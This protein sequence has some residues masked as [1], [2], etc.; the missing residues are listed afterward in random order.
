MIFHNNVSFLYVR[1]ISD[2][3]Q[4]LKQ[5]L[6]LYHLHSGTKE[7]LHAT[8]S[9]RSSFKIWVLGRIIH[10]RVYNLIYLDCMKNS[11]SETHVLFDFAQ[12]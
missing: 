4:Q 6:I 9:M 8:S 1:D 7:Q 11:A 3:F 12:F 2:F 10:L 5:L